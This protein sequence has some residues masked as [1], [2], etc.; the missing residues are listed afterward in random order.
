MSHVLTVAATDQS[1]RSAFFSSSSPGVDLAAPGENVLGAV[2]TVYDRTGY[3]SLDG[4]SFS[5]PIVSAAAA[6]V[7]TMR[8]DLDNTQL[9]ELLRSTARDVEAP[10]FDA[11]TGFGVVDIPAALTATAPS[12]DPQEPNDDIDL[13]KPSGLFSTGNAPLTTSTRRTAALHARVDF[14]E[15]PEDVYRIWVPGLRTVTVSMK[16]TKPIALQIWRPPTRS[17][18]EVGSA[19]QRDLAATVKRVATSAT[20]TVTN[21]SKLGAYYYSDVFVT[22]TNASYDLRVASPKAI[23]TVKQAATR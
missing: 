22:N 16:A 11:Q 9:F 23:K 15:D 5:S 8:S 10:G 6:W 17:V 12:R 20:L 19:K 4:T 18:S 13:V 3:T 7:W 1:D 14:T 2:P 21:R